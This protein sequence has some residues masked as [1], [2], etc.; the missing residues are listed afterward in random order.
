[1]TPEKKKEEKDKINSFGL[2]GLKMHYNCKSIKHAKILMQ[3]ITVL[4]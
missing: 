1:M 3:H 2:V 4:C